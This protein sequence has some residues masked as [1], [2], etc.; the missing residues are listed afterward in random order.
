MEVFQ[1]PKF[2][3][4]EFFSQVSSWSISET[5]NFSLIPNHIS[6]QDEPQICFSYSLTTVDW[7]PYSEWKDGGNFF[8]PSKL[9]LQM[10]GMDSGYSRFSFPA[11]LPLGHLI[12]KHY[13]SHKH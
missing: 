6:T 9:E 5:K 12:D 2:N 13:V 11:D 7:A 4:V 3:H 10:Q 8:S 1:G